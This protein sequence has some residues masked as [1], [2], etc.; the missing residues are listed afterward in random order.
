MW[1]L[2]LYSCVQLI[3]EM[4]TAFVEE[5]ASFAADIAK[6]RVQVITTNYFQATRVTCSNQQVAEGPAARTGG[7]AAGA[8]A[9]LMTA[10]DVHAYASLVWPQLLPP[11]VS[12]LDRMPPTATVTAPASTVSASAGSSGV[13]AASG[14]G[15]TR[16]SASGAY[17]QRQYQAQQQLPYG[18][19]GRGAMASGAGRSR[20]PAPYQFAGA[21]PGTM[22]MRPGYPLGLRPGGGGLPYGGAGMT[23]PGAGGVVG[24]PRSV[25]SVGSAVS[26]G[27]QVASYVGV[28]PPGA[29]Q[30]RPVLPGWVAQGALHSN[31]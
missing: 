15:A 23:R 25:V 9:P 6:A 12:E 18:Y 22:M 28:V 14:S 3:D 30:P 31:G 7:A 21:G 20:N 10:S 19:T 8:P 4:L 27:V 13:A 5:T 16:A 1:Y 17:S 24:T 11:A 26:G 29:A 2:I